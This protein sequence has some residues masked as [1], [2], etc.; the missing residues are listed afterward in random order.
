MFRFSQF[1][2]SSKAIVRTAQLM[3]QRKCVLS[4]QRLSLLKRR[5]LGIET[6]MFHKFLNSLNEWMNESDYYWNKTTYFSEKCNI[7]QTAPHLFGL[8]A[9]GQSL[10]HSRNHIALKH[11]FFVWFTDDFNLWTKRDQ[12]KE[13]E[14]L[15][16]LPTS[17]IQ[18]LSINMIIH[19]SAF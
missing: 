6:K 4:D 7:Y 16:S 19:K 15:I 12:R 8:T 5:I 11:Y 9:V 3:W 13:N 1:G 17:W 14:N 18:H 10:F 2:S